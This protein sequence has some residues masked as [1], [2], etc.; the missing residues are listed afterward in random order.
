[1]N[2]T[3]KMYFFTNEYFFRQP[4][5]NPGLEALVVDE[6]E[7]RLR[8]GLEQGLTPPSSPPRGKKR[9]LIFKFI[10]FFGRDDL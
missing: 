1:M 8:L 6:G 3:R 5:M 2:L 9:F 4:L 7:R 10:F